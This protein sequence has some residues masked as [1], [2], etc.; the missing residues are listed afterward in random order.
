MNNISFNPYNRTDLLIQRTIRSKFADC[1]VLT[2]AHRLH[3][4]IDSDRVLVMDFGRAL[5][6]DTPHNLLT[7][8]TGIFKEMVHTLGSSEVERF[9]HTAQN[10]HDAQQFIANK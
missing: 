8:N 6:F 5:E 1:T 4:I 3:T 9:C 2:I 7:Q 10:K